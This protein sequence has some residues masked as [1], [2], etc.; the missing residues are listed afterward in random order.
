MLNIYYGSENTDKEK[1]I[2]D[3]VKGRTLLLV[4]DQFSLQAERDAFFYLE[5]KSLIDIRIVDFSSL[6]HKIVNETGGVF[7][8]LIDKYGRHMLLMKIIEDNEKELRIYRGLKNRNSFIEMV[9]GFIS[10]L[11][12]FEITV[13]ILSGVMEELDE[14][15]FLRYKLEDILKIY[16]AYEKAIEGKYLDAEDYITFYGDRILDS[17]MVKESDI[18][19]YGFDTFTPKNFLVMEKLL[20]CAGDLNVV[21]TYEKNDEEGETFLKRDAA[22][23]VADDREELF[24]ITGYIIEKFKEMAYGVGEE[25]SVRCINRND[26]KNVWEKGKNAIELFCGFNIYAE[27]DR[28]ASRILKLVKEAGCKFG[29]IVVIC[30]DTEVRTGIL[31]RTFLR[32]GIPVFVD[33]KRKVLHHPAV[34]FLLSL[35][36]TASAGYKDGAVM[37]LIKSGLIGFEEESVEKLENY[38]RQ[39]KIRGSMWKK[40]FTRQGD[41]YSVEELNELNAMRADIVNLVDGMKS[42][43]GRY[44]SAGDKIKG[45]YDFL[46]DRFMMEERIAEMVRQQEREGFEEGAAETAQSWNIICTILNQIVSTLG[47]EKV[48]DGQL[49][50]LMEAGFEEIEIGLVPVTSDMVIIGTMQRTRLSRIKALFVVGANEGLIPLESGDDGLLSDREKSVLE[51]FEVEMAKTEKVMRQEEKMA[52]YRM[53]SLPSEKLYISCSMTDEKGEEMRP[54]SVFRKLSEEGRCENTVQEYETAPL[55]TMYSKNGAVSYM[56]DAFRDYMDTGDIDEYWI[57]AARWYERNDFEAF[58]KVKDGMNFDNRQDT[59]GK[60]LADALYRGDKAQIEVSASRLEKYSSCPFAHFIAYGLVPDEERT[61]EM[62]AREIGDIYHECMMKLSRKLEK[63]EEKNWDSITFEECRVQIEDILKDIA[64]K[65]REGL[66]NS[67]R[68]EE[69]RSERIVDICSGVAWIMIEQVRKGSIDKMYFERSFSTGGSLPPIKV[70][71]GEKEVLIKGK[72]DRMDILDTEGAYGEKALRIIDYKTGGDDVNTD[73]FREGYKL[74]LMVYLKAAIQQ[75]NMKPAGLFL[76][77]IK[78]MDIDGDSTAIKPGEEDF[79]LRM[80]N[81]YRMEGIVLNEPEIIRSMDG[82]FESS[83]H[84]IPVK[85][86]KKTGGYAPSAGGDLF[87]ESEFRELSEQVDRQ[88]ERICTEI[89]EGRVDIIPKREKKKDMEGNFKNSCKYCDYKSIC[90]FDTSFNGCRFEWV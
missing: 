48:S 77:K 53:L 70:K 60:E 3:N 4:P 46:N 79:K 27:A 54:S 41:V 29:D 18:W 71:A 72:I 25:V 28:A 33:K 32:W 80:E 76:F 17:E 50:K 22:F 42:A 30:N 31:R 6:G 89:Y 75:G 90:M 45:L 78:E 39:F 69:Y 47:E 23:V 15:S 12:R 74:Q 40:E 5:E 8:D 43:M 62:G 81:A 44:N 13:D 37:N 24:S 21:M 55:D 26:R 63:G 1:F 64:G 16:R 11:K 87:T 9:N 56:A 67:G 10:E 36:E 68:P 20:K 85:R 88:I 59:I 65:Y 35:M 66:I 61:F 2:F 83:S 34:R 73:Y 49:M 14:S 51:G 19:I 84:V 86:L 38:T 57:E 58:N 7:P 52:L 82:E